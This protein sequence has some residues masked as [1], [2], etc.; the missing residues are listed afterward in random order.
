MSTA[1]ATPEVNFSDLLQHPTETVAKLEGR[2]ALRVSRRG[3]EDLVLTTA[4]RASQDHELVDVATRM[5]IAVMSN[6]VARSMH[7]LETLPQ[8]FPWVRF[9]PS[10]ERATFTQ[11][12]IDVIK[13]CEDLDTP[14]PVL[15]VIAEWRHTAEVYADPEL[16]AAVRRSVKTDL[17]VVAEPQA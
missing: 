9:L 17:G 7:L 15:Q 8:I 3:A 4:A 12:L 10:E 16:F 1:A 5:F 11:E 14:A 13:A 6:P 2:T